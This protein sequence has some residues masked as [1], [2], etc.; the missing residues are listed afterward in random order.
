[1][2]NI[3]SEDEIKIIG[4]NG[5]KL[6]KIKKELKKDINSGVTPWQ[7]EQKA[8]DLIKKAGGKPSFQ[9]VPKYHWATCINTNSGVVHGIP[10]SQ[11]PFQ[12]GDIV[13]IDIGMYYKGFHTDSAFTVPVGQVPYEVEHFLSTGRRTLKEAI[14]QATPGKYI[15]NI[16]LK[17]QEILEKNN[18]SPVRDLTGHGVG[19]K[20]H[21]DPQIPCF[22]QGDPTHSPKIQKGFVLAIEVIYTMGSPELVLAEDGWTINT[23]DGKIAGL[24]EETV[25]VVDGHPVVLTC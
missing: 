19:K 10:T 18:Y 24:F 22:W 8:Q 13:S 25:G 2:I 17:I 14:A 23:K 15:A 3:K 5:R 4:E 9:M 21:E 16:S 20:L 11:S 12:E 7:I 1:M 6:A